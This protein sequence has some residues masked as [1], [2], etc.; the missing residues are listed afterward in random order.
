MTNLTFSL[1][2][3]QQEI[4]NSNARFKV[5][6]AGR[7][8]GKSFFAA[9]T[10]IIEALRGTSANG[11]TSTI[12]PV[13]Y[14][15]PTYG[16]AKDIM[17]DQLKELAKPV[18]T[19]V[20]EK[21]LTLQVINGRKIVLKGADNEETLRGVGLWYL[22]LD[23]YADMKP[24]VFD[25]ILRP[26]LSDYLAP[27]LFIGTPKGKNHFYDF[28]QLAKSGMVSEMAAF[29]FTSADNPYMSEREIDFARQTMSKEAFAQ[30]YMADF[31]AAGSGTF[32]KEMFKIVEKSPFEKPGQ[33]V[34]AVDL[35]GFSDDAKS[36]LTKSAL[37]KR[38]E[39]AFAVV[40]VGQEGWF[41]RDVVSGRWGVREAALRLLRTAQSNQV[42]RL[43]IEKGSLKN[44]VMPYLS[45]SMRRLG[46]FRVPEEL[47]HGGQKKT[48][49]INWALQGR[50]QHGK[51][52]FKKAP[53]NEKLIGQLLDFPNP[54][55]HDD[56]IDALAYIDQLCTVAYIDEDDAFEDDW[57]PLDLYAGY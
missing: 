51:I 1:H 7:R 38:D 33:I 10:L 2:P 50:F 37:N 45:D 15:A 32:K 36:T 53:W 18:T 24:H 30:E 28:Y 3:K 34:M 41:V 56:L 22:V 46:Y 6:P 42:A 16:Q 54:M 26:T 44:A 11:R 5:V 40:E 57:E 13:W 4:Y 19:K 17:W 20:W 39:H 27:A 43:G 8:G 25:V 35:A 48:E 29:K 55:S 12:P 47:T 52:W 21:D 14:V 9:V 31:T 23:E 49:R